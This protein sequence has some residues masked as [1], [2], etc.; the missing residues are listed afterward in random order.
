MTFISEHCLKIST[1][2][3]L[4]AKTQTDPYLGD[5]VKQCEVK[6]INDPYLSD[7]A[8]EGGSGPGHAQDQSQ[9]IRVV[10][11]GREE[12]D[13][14]AAGQEQVPTPVITVLAHCVQDEVKSE[15]STSD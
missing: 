12:R 3:K 6:S 14:G 9:L 4:N 2:N 10:H 5:S 11:E 15:M 8:A 13:V 1:D 7:T